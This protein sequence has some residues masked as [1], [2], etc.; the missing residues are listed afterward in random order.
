VAVNT[1][2][3]EY[4]IVLYFGH[5]LELRLKSENAQTVRKLHYQM[6]Y[7]LAPNG[8]ISQ[9]RERITRNSFAVRLLALRFTG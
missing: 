5:A 8:P 6:K 9:L 7:G 1:K 4:F 2:P 3:Y